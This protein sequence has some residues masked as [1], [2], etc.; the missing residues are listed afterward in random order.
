MPLR[1]YPLLE[2][3]DMDMVSRFLD[4]AKDWEKLEVWMLTVWTGVRTWPKGWAEVVGPTT[5]NYSS[6]GRR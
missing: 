4:E 1:G 6:G 2:L 3:H 5:R